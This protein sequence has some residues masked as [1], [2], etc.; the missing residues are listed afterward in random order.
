MTEDIGGKPQSN[1]GEG[2]ALGLVDA[3]SECQSDGELGAPES[4]GQ[5]LAV[6]VVD[7]RNHD[8]LPMPITYYEFALYETTAHIA[9]L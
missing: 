2:L 5:I 1:L 3:H 9:D 4:E 7:P 6:V 8:R